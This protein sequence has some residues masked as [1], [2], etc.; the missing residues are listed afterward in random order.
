[1]KPESFRAEESPA[2]TSTDM[3]FI[4]AEDLDTDHIVHVFAQK[5]VPEKEIKITKKCWESTFAHR[6]DNS[7]L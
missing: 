4:L 5:R 1:M 2:F 7:R 3:E 6:T